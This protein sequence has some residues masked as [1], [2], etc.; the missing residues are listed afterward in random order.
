MREWDY[1]YS[2]H[3][4]PIGMLVI[5][6]VIVM[7]FWRICSKAGYAGI[8]ALLVF[9]PVVNIVLLY[10]YWPESRKGS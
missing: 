10:R 1:A 4:G 9:I 7:P 8:M 2:Y 6:A 3:V 5:A